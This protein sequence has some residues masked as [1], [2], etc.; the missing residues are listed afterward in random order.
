[1]KRIIA[2]V[3]NVTRLYA[4]YQDLVD[5]DAGVPGIGLLHGFTGAGK[6]TAVAQL[7]IR[8]DGVFVRA[9]A[10]WTPSALLGALMSD[11]GGEP[12]GKNSAMLQF[13]CDRLAVSQ[14]PVFV[15]EA[16]YLLSNPKMLETLRDIHDMTGVP[17]IIIGM[18]GFEK[19]ITHRAQFC[20][21]ISQFVEFLPLDLEDAHV[22]VKSTC[23]I[24]LESDLIGR[25]WTASGGSIGKMAVGL[26]RVEQY[27]KGRELDS[28]DAK[29]W[30]DRQFFLGHLP[31]A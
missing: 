18:A 19:R 12:L 7:V 3:R 28:M 2:P 29:A 4:A 1:M 10:V 13:V 25:L 27:A 17:V 22:L 26:S 6:S 30:G 31:K 5:R 9:N 14:R 15:D 11:L 20:R 23:E 16:D 8:V 24:T 21:R